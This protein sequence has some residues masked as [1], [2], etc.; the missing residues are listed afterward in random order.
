MLLCGASTHRP[1]LI[2]PDVTQAL[3]L[4]RAILL[5]PRKSTKAR[6]V[7]AAYQVPQLPHGISKTSCR[8]SAHYF[9]REGF[10][11][12]R[13]RIRN[14]VSNVSSAVQN[15]RQR[16]LPKITFTVSVHLLL[17]PVRSAVR[18]RRCRGCQRALWH[19]SI[20]RLTIRTRSWVE[21]ERWLPSSPW[22]G[23]RNGWAFHEVT[24][25]AYL[26]SVPA[27]VRFWRRFAPPGGR[28]QDLIPT[29]LS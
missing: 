1:W 23:A 13:R 11:C 22:D 3:D 9:A 26:R 2:R 19:L 8:G 28:S 15:L 21:Y 27:T 6:S 12:K 14:R 18:G 29:L 25:A 7:I 17:Q 16:K 5:L 10:H 20:H 24:D 4:P